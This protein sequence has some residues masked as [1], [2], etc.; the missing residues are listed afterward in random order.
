MS[1]STSDAESDSCSSY[2]DEDTEELDPLVNYLLFHSVLTCQVDVSKSLLENGVKAECLLSFIAIET[3]DSLLVHGLHSSDEHHAIY[4]HYKACCGFP[5]HKPN[6]LEMVCFERD[7]K[8]R[9]VML[10]LL[11]RFQ[12]DIPMDALS[13]VV[14]SI[15]SDYASWE[16]L[17]TL[18]NKTRSE[19]DNS[20]Y[21]PCNKFTY[22]SLLS[23]EFISHKRWEKVQSCEAKTHM[24]TVFEDILDRLSVTEANI[25]HWFMNLSFCLEKIIE[26]KESA[27]LMLYLTR[28]QQI[29][30]DLLSR[31]CLDTAYVERMQGILEAKISKAISCK[32]YYSLYLLINA[33][34]RYPHGDNGDQ[35]LL[36]C[37]IQEDL[38]AFVVLLQAFDQSRNWPCPVND[39]AVLFAAKFEADQN[40]LMLW[41][42]LA[43]GGNVNA[44][45]ME[46]GE[47][48][49]SN[50]VCRRCL[51][52]IEIALKYGVDVNH[53]G[54]NQRTPLFKA[55]T[56]HDITIIRLLLKANADVDLGYTNRYSFKYHTPLSYALYERHYDTAQILL[57]AG[58]KVPSRSRILFSP[59][60]AED[61]EEPRDVRRDWIKDFMWSP[62]P[63]KYQC[64]RLF[65]SFVGTQFATVMKTIEYPTFLKEFLSTERLF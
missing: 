13:N 4:K 39:E 62:A 25:S 27:L 42:L 18:S 65:R 58:A 63:L 26:L 43:Y 59:H 12:A 54:D 20:Q 14:F 5:E 9:R 22:V 51:L 38:F 3:I 52:G 34:L 7:D 2:T 1:T 44:L 8:K 46:Y 33:G 31:G 23:N 41:L 56:I 28:H 17:C 55:V 45:E 24:L 6:L 30:D 47:S 11:L 49:L 37:I 64:R 40:V 53:V 16:V 61:E 15:H 57:A 32:A 50:L 29:E 10:N 36:Y 19:N 60:C 35:P 48:V 21:L